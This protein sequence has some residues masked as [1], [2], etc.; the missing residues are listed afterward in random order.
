M[1]PIRPVAFLAIT[2]VTTWSAAA[3]EQGKLEPNLEPLRPWLGK[4]WKSDPV[5]HAGKTTVDVSRWERALNGKAVRMLH[6]INDGEYGGETIATWDE[7]QKSI[8]YHYFTTAG[9]S[10]TGTMKMEEGKLVTHET[11]TGNSGGVTEVRGTGEMRADG[12]YRIKTEY[13][14][15]GRWEPARDVVYREDATASV[16]FK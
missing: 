13:L 1:R 15:N 10:T 5:T 3:A 8:V 11:V 6:S 4:T 9:F 2:F 12:T 14:K 16:L 7:K